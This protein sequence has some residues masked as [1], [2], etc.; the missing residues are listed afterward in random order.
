MANNRSQLRVAVLGAGP[1]GLS[2]AAYLSRRGVDVDVIEKSPRIGG[3]Q[4]SVCIEGFHFDTGTFLYFDNHGLFDA[5]PGLKEHCVPIEYRPFSV[6]PSG[7]LDRYPFTPRQFLRDNGVATTAWAVADLLICKIGCF[8]RDTVEKF[9]RFYMG[10]TIYRRSG[11]QNYIHRLHDLPDKEIDIDFARQRMVEIA[12]R[13]FTNMFRR[14]IRSR[15]AHIPI[16]QFYVRPAEGFD[17]FFEIIR[18][19]LEATGVNLRRNAEATSVV[20]DGDEFV[21]TLNGEKRRYNRIVST[22]PIPVM[23]RL[24]GQAPKVRVETRSLISLFYRGKINH[25]AAVLFNFTFEAAWKR[26]TVFSRFYGPAK[27]EEDYFTVEITSEHGS[28]EN[29]EAAQKEF[30]IFSERFRICKGTPRLV[31][32]SVTPN[33]YPV[34]RRGESKLVASEKQR[35]QHYGIDI[36]GRQG[37]FEYRLSNWMAKRAEDTAKA[38]AGSV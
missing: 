31:G 27:G 14:L 38:I 35:L 16:R 33:A 15:R 6:L 10:G 22:I 36:L 4:E 29:V 13:S 32:H 30:E 7:K 11:L 9:A 20:R 1:A 34:Y 25:H 21:V 2:A 3:L 24:I 17:F 26:I 19:D 8:R 37:N 12:N 28:K 5:F 23:L 18:D